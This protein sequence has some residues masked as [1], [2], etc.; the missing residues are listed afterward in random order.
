MKAAALLAA[1]QRILADEDQREIVCCL[2]S[3]GPLPPLNGLDPLRLAARLKSDKKT[4][5]GRIHFVLPERI[6]AV[7]ITSDID[8]RFVLSAIEEALAC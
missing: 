7:K 1:R 8:E 4:V 6:G 2:N 5:Q 3:Y